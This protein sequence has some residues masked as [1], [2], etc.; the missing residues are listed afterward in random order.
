MFLFVKFLKK[1]QNYLATGLTFLLLKNRG[2][3]VNTENSIIQQINIILSG[4]LK[5]LKKF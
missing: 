3:R 1:A 5:D 4:I 2:T